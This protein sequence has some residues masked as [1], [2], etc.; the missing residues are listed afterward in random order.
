MEH[1]PTDISEFLMM[2]DFSAIKKCICLLSDKTVMKK[3]R[4]NKLE[5]A[6]MRRLHDK[7]RTVISE[8]CHVV[9]NVINDSDSTLTIFAAPSYDTIHSILDLTSLACQDDFQR[10][11]DTLKEEWEIQEHEEESVKKDVRRNGHSNWEEHLK[12]LYP[13]EPNEHLRE[14]VI[15]AILFLR[16][17]YNQ[18]I[19]NFTKYLEEEDKIRADSNKCFALFEQQWANLEKQIEDSHINPYDESNIQKYADNILVKELHGKNNKKHVCKL[20][21]NYGDDT[22]KD[23]TEQI[24]FEYILHKKAFDYQAELA[25]IAQKVKNPIL[26][27][28]ATDKNSMLKQLIDH[29]PEITNLRKANDGQ[30]QYRVNGYIIAFVVVLAGKER[31]AMNIHKYIGQCYQAPTQY[32]NIS[33]KVNEILAVI[34]QK[35]DKSH[36]YDKYK[37]FCD[38][39]R[40]YGK[41]NNKPSPTAPSNFSRAF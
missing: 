3:I 34:Y 25:R 22:T 23:I 7:L 5:G 9:E 2:T 18:L 32:S 28:N 17:T 11:C 40:N 36:I 24:L 8:L 20:Y 6:D 37:N 4:K 35:K 26:V 21:H 27:K 41:S 38:D 15:K 33:P 12:K 14:Q 39:V 31:L 30:H 19:S 13:P 16:W 29:L 10:N 1:T